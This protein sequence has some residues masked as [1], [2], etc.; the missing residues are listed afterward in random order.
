MSECRVTTCTGWTVKTPAPWW[1]VISRV[2]EAAMRKD[3]HLSWTGAL[4]HCAVVF[5]V[6]ATMG[7][8]G[9]N[10]ISDQTPAGAIVGN[11]GKSNYSPSVIQTGDVQ[12]FWWCGQGINPTYRSQDSDAI[13]YETVN[14]V[15]NAKSAPIVVLAETQGSWDSRYTCNPRVIGGTFANPLG[16]GQTYSYEMFYV[17]STSGLNNSIGAAFSHDG[18]QWV[19]YPQPV[20][21]STSLYTYGVGQPAAYNANGQSSITLFYED[22]TPI[23]HHLEVTST[24]GIHFNAVGTL[25][26]N[27]LDKDYTGITWGDMG[28]DS[29][30]NSWY[31]AFNLPARPQN[32]SGDILER[33]QWGFQLYRIPNSSL[34]TGAIPWQMV[35]TVDTNLTGYESNFLPSLL[36]DG[37]GNVNVGSYP[38][39]ELFVSTALPQPS[40]DASPKSAGELGDPSHWAIAVN[41]YDPS[42]TTLTLNRYRNAD[43]YEVT[44]G[45]IDPSADFALDTTLGHLY[46]APQNGADQAIYNCKNGST[47]YFVSFDPACVG[48]RV[49]GLNGYGY[50]RPPAGAATVA[51]YSCLTKKGRPFLS[52]YPNCEGNNS[53]LLFAYVLP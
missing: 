52:R 15:T 17:G 45:W 18:I 37:Y 20:I 36:H 44:S 47:G 6:L 10:S 2:N 12:K 40:W 32:T 49:L 43:T 5:A 7:F 35:K 23:I 1:A 21:P 51:L 31:A 29:S 50:L 27:G 24:D 38:K 26:T 33:G 19:K 28:Y 8:A 3:M 46:A 30:T 22:D 34:I 4:C 11:G 14:T 39:L 53:G 42:Q 16:D 41:T 48:Q 13:Y 25:T 9:C